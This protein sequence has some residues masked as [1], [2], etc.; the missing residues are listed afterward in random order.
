MS[1]MNGIPGTVAGAIYG[2]AGAY[3]DNI[4]DHLEEVKCFDGQNSI[5]LTKDQYDTGYRDSIFKHNKNLIILEGTF[6]GFPTSSKED[7]QKEADHIL[8]IRAQKYP[9]NT[10]CPGSFFKNVI[11]SEAPPEALSK[12]PPDKI[13]FGKIPAGFL[14]ESVGAKGDQ[15]GQ[16]KVADNHGNTFINLGDGTAQDF[17]NLAK[18]YYLKVKD[19]FG[20]SLQPEV[21]LLNLPPFE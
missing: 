5:T 4:R 10:K 15:L 1:T 9:P 19:Q 12:I 7:L 2:S 13:K 18:K 17:Y 8:E 16:I 20:I 11:T 21:Q 14:L 3:G 6:S